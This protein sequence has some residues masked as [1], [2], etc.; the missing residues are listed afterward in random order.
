MGLDD[1]AH[2]RQSETQ[3]AVFAGGIGENAAAVR[4][5][6]ADAYPSPD[7]LDIVLIGDAARIAGAAAKLGPVTRT[8]LAAP[9]YAP[10][11]R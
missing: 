1:A 11:A 4:A 2:Y 9:D 5:V 10:A 8:T 6:I 3:S 7:D